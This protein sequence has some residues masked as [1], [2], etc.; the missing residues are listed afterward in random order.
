M[1]LLKRLQSDEIDQY[2]TKVIKKK[3]IQYIFINI[4]SQSSSAKIF[5]NRINP[6]ISDLESNNHDAIVS[7][8]INLE[9]SDQQSNNADAIFSK[10][11]NSKI[12]DQVNF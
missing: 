7:N 11:I 3:I 2:L 10:Q 6:E 4:I 5:E 12:E 8:Q 1:V 9:I